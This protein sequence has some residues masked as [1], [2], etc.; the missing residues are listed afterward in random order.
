[1]YVNLKAHSA[2]TNFYYAISPGSKIKINFC[3]I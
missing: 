1:M 3:V 2:A